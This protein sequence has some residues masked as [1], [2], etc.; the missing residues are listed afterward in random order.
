MI[1]WFTRHGVAANLLAVIILAGGFFAL[2]QIKVELFPEFS[3]DR[4][5]VSVPYPGAAPEEVERQIIERIEERL[6]DL[7]GIKEVTARA[8]EGFGS[9][10]IEV[11]TNYDP[12]RLLDDVK[13][14][15]D[16][17]D[18]FPEDSEK[19]IVEEVLITR[20]VINLAIHGELDE[21][22]LKEL[23]EE[24]REDLIQLPR[25]YAVPSYNIGDYLQML[26]TGKI[27]ELAQAVIVGPSDIS[28]VSI[29]GVR[30]YEIAVEV[31]ENVLREHDLT[32]QQ[33][34]DRVRSGSVDL[35]GGT[36]KTPS[37]EILLRTQGQA[38]R[39]NEFEALVLLTRPDGTHLTLGDIATVNDGFTDVALSTRFNGKPGVTLTINEVGEQNPLDISRKVKQY[40]EE[41]QQQ[42]PEGITIETYRD[43]SFYLMGRL[44]TM[45][46]N[47]VIG[48]ILVLGVLS[49]FLRPSLAFWVTLGIPISFMG[50]VMVMPWMDTS[51]N[52][53]S[54]FGFIL[55][56]GI[57][58]DDAIVVGESVFTEFQRSK[59]PGIESSIRG[60]KAVATPVTYAVLT[61]AVAFTPLLM[62][63]GFQGKFLIAIPL[64]VI[65][66]LMFSL[67]ESKLILPYHLSLCKV[68]NQGRESMNPLL[69][70]QRKI[71]DGL[72]WAIDAYYRPI[73]KLALDYRYIT[74]AVFTVLLMLTGSLIQG[75]WIKVVPF[76][77]V[78]SDYIFARLTYP[79]GTP[80]QITMRGI[81]QMEDAVEVVRQQSLDAG[82]PDPFG[83]VRVSLGT[84]T[85]GGGPSGSGASNAKSSIAELEIELRKDEN[86]PEA[87]SAVLL[88]KRWREAIGS[89]PGS[90]SLVFDAV[91][92]G[93]Q[94]DPIDIRI[95]TD[96]LGDLRAISN[97]IKDALATY[98]GIT[99][100][101]DNLADSQQE[102]QL[103]TLPKGEMLGITQASLG[104]QVRSAFFGA[105]AQ[106]VQRGRDDVRVMVRYPRDERESIG[107]LMNMRV[108]APDGTGVPL[109]EV[110]EVKSG[111]GFATINR[112]DGQRVANVVA[113]A[114]KQ[115]IDLNTVKTELT[116]TVIPDILTRYNGA[117]IEFVGE[118]QEVE[119]GNASLIA[120]TYMV[121]LIMYA[122]LAIPF[123]SYLQPLIIMFV[124]PFSIVG[125]VAGHFIVGWAKGYFPDALPL[126]R[127]SLFGIVALTGIVVNDS[128]VLV[129]YI[130]KQRKED[131]SIIEAV[132]NSGAARFRPIL[133]TSLTTFA[134]LAPILLETSLQAQFLIP[135]AVSLSFGVGYA[136]LVTLLLVPASY[137]IL[138]DVK[139]L[140][141]WML[142]RK[143]VVKSSL[144]G[145][146]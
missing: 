136:T 86:R 56:L 75:G 91:A 129:D 37:G 58:V 61:T 9:V 80:E 131:G 88:A 43:T 127:L 101:R 26:F 113:D 77:K 57:V 118:S 45:I 63:P 108:H 66:T 31:S 74:L 121:L 41:K 130:N 18:T 13:T 135:M 96:Q 110:A 92:T 68:G 99:D 145:F 132:W 38:Y 3:L 112:V 10:S 114:E 42:L 95:A 39:G 84:Q 60:A 55:V 25:S 82:R 1:A 87:D 49:L 122:L 133:L 6:E 20:Q 90:K 30:D 29:N 2:K 146:D 16:A 22:A 109:E 65:P 14:R 71:S 142:L 83:G 85:E 104:N 98:E 72:E 17:I 51:I 89:V 79:E 73:L 40:V 46:S 15:I 70:L 19:A 12:R 35:P 59:K 48:L 103:R 126:S 23:A 123:R 144:G 7:R 24:V 94:G 138:E 76:P 119:E 124:I 33:V 93:G 117:S 115:Q 5:V 53:I 11:E 141:A 50:T 54:L 21:R 78:P 34:V 8:S 116:E 107:D 120:S 67:V 125:A 47:G 81:K 44:N 4:V 27:T 137:L 97:D 128:L 134:G 111:L 143:R 105:E 139:S 52:L 62:L 140:L 64:V 28:Q 100:I 106:R 36:L 69:K 102:I 32:F